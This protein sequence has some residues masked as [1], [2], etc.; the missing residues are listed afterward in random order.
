MPD[1][2]EVPPPA[3]P[4]KHLGTRLAVG[5]DHTLTRRRVA[6]RARSM[7][8]MLGRLGVLNAE[9]FETASRAAIDS[10]IGYYG[11]STPIDRKTCERIEVMR[12]R[13]L[14]RLGHR[15][16][17]GHAAQVY[18][19]AARG[20]LGASHSYAS[21]AAA[22]LDETVRVLALPPGTPSRTALES[23]VLL[24]AAYDCK[25]L[26]TGSYISSS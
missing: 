11:R 12:R 7:L 18:H 9:Q 25:T 10:V 4:Y 3:E 19:S 16:N 5:I 21:A 15:C 8:G 26:S 17:D 2:R 6:A 14:A 1:Q 20:G 23:S 24:A 22:L 13:Q